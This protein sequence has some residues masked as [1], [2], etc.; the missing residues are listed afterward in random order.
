MGVGS[1]AFFAL[2]QARFRALA[3]SLTCAEIVGLV[4]DWHRLG[5]AREVLD[6]VGFFFFQKMENIVD[7]CRNVCQMYPKFACL[8][9]KPN[10]LT[11]NYQLHVR[12][13]VI[14]G[15]DIYV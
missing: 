8:T 9:F 14:T 6:F 2:T 7:M 4:E 12:K 1:P 11:C 10:F 5:A 13:D 15:K 3:P